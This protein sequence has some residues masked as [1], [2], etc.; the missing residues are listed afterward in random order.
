MIAK[1][2]TGKPFEEGR[3]SLGVAELSGGGGAVLFESRAPDDR[4][5][6]QQV[7]VVNGRSTD[8]ETEILVE[9]ETLE[10]FGETEDGVDVRPT[11][12][13][14][15]EALGLYGGTTAGKGTWAWMSPKMRIGSATMGMQWRGFVAALV[16][17]LFTAFAIASG[18]AAE[19]PVTVAAAANLTPVLPALEAA[20]AETSATELRIVTGS[21]GKLATQILNGAPFDVFLS[22]DESYPAKLEAE[23]RCAGKP[24]PYALGV[25]AF[26]FRKEF[27]DGRRPLGADWTAVRRIALADPELAPY[28]RAASEYLGREDGAPGFA[29]DCAHG[30]SISQTAQFLAAGA[31]DGAFLA[32]SQVGA[33]PPGTWIRAEVPRETYTPIRQA[34]VLLR[35]KDGGEPTSGARAFYAFLFGAE[36]R[37]IFEGAGYRTP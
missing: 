4:V 7:H 9:T 23:G 10:V 5:H 29:G 28:G 32:L 13:R 3:W 34:V 12:I 35:G 36:A 16:G 24:R 31:A 14:T 2:V 17:L 8:L 18:V 26:V 20:F 37:R 21:S 33:F 15:S 6:L 1:H 30:Q 27:A 25:L 11:G 22:A 19:E